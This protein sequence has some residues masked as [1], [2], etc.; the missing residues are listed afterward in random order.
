MIINYLPDVP[1]SLRHAITSSVNLSRS[2]WETARPAPIIRV[3]YTSS[4]IQ[5]MSRLLLRA[6]ASRMINTD[7]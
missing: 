5:T 4:T 3:R 7:L 1:R 6:A 2:Q